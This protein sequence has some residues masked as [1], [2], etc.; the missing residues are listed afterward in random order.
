MPRLPHS[1]WANWLGL[2]R[3]ATTC[4]TRCAAVKAHETTAITAQV[5]RHHRSSCSGGAFARPYSPD[6]GLKSKA[7]GVNKASTI[8]LGSSL[9]A[10]TLDCR[11]LYSTGDIRMV[12]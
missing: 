11:K 7:R 1:D 6:C 3:C 2:G 5:G 8:F 10:C 9:L 12:E 4:S